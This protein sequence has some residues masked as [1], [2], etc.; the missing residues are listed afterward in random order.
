MSYLLE[1]RSFSVQKIAAIREHLRPA[2]DLVEDR[3][4]VYATGS[5]GRLEAGKRSDL[6]LFIVVSTHVIDKNGSS[7]EV[8]RLGG[9]DEIKLK[10]CLIAAVESND[11]VE[12]DGD[13]RY[14]ESHR[15][16]D[17]TRWL[18]T[19]EDDYRNT[20]TGRMLLLLESKCLVG[21]D[22]YGCLIGEV[23]D[24]YFKDFVGNES[25]FIPAFF[26]N[27]VLRMWRTFCVNY[28]S[29]RRRGGSDSRIKNLKLKYSRMLTCYSAV[30]KVL[31]V[32]VTKGTVTPQD[33]RNIVEMTPIERLEAVVNECQDQS[34]N[35]VV[36]LIISSYAD[37]LKLVHKDKEDAFADFIAN[38]RDWKERSYQFGRN[39]A[40]ALSKVN[41]L[42]QQN[43]A[44]YRMIVA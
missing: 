36:G 14:L 12:F 4:C 20:L 16:K 27:D 40:E 18:G 43:N 38:E 42:N 8:S 1:A 24:E 13:G 26:V 2:Q 22:L 19:R 30:L 25:S 6:D 21:E 35:E 33:V 9:I 10:G 3:A 44:L 32:Y 41:K 17:Y 23:I 11:I 15:D 28:E 37:F 34:V 5:F 31:Y 29:R 39:F 7:Q